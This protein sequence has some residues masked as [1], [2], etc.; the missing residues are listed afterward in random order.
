M[1]PF[2]LRAIAPLVASASITATAMF[3]PP[4]ISVRQVT[5]GMPVPA[6][7]VL[8]VAA[9]HHVQTE[10]LAVTARAEGIQ[11][12]KR[13]SKPLQLTNQS[14][15]TYAVLKQWEDGTPWVLVF[16]AEQGPEGK[17]GIADALVRVDRS[18]A[19]RGI[20]YPQHTWSVLEGWSG[21]TTR[22]AVEAALASLNAQK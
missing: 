19:I 10:L 16:A 9:H 20:E 7:A 14:D 3:G 18:G 2:L 8:V 5:P 1:T 15:G 11:N 12:G 22:N 4:S 13:I 17:H 6:G 21:K